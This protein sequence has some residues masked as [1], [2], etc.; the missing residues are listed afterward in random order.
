MGLH[1]GQDRTLSL[2]DRLLLGLEAIN[3]GDGEVGG[4]VILGRLGE[5]GVLVLLGSELDMGLGRDRAA[6]SD[7]LLS[8][9]GVISHVLLGDLGGLGSAL[10]GGLT[11]LGSLSTND[12]AGM[13]KLVVNDL[14]VGLVDEGSE[15]D[16]GG[17]DQSKAP[18]RNDL[19]E[20]IGEES[21]E[22]GD[23]RGRD[24]L[25]EEDALSL[26]TK[27]FTSSLTSPITASS[28]SLGTV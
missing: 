12:L 10:L 27:K 9:G 25:G 15:E 24:I 1:L 19:D 2:D 14:L 11:E 17:G 13:V 5:I 21:S 20:V 22:G 18:V 6:T 28:V 8:L 26:D 4:L 3:R 7:Q 23:S 16:G